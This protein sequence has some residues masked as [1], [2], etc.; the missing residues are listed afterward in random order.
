VTLL[1]GFAGR[2]PMPLTIAAGALIAGTIAA[3]FAG[4][5][6][7]RI[8]TYWGTATLLI[9][10]TAALD[11]RVRFSRRTIW[12]LAAWSVAH[13]AGGLL[14]LPSG[15]ILFAAWIVE[16]V[17]RFDQ[18]VHLWTYFAVT[19]AGWEFLSWL[20]GEREDR[21]ILQAPAV[22]TIGWPGRAATAAVMACG[23]GAL[24]EVVE[25]VVAENVAGLTSGGYANSVWDIMFN[26]AGAGAAAT[27]LAITRSAQRRA[28]SPTTS[29]PANTRGRALSQ[30]Q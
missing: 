6:P 21:G 7:V 13:S 5:G 9:G 30:R 12:M 20:L 22:T 29:A 1:R 24:N 14:V 16:G 2:H 15:T 10:I 23:I 28:P 11:D 26:T 25:Q 4:V 8:A 3:S 19:F 27:W 18:A 17:V